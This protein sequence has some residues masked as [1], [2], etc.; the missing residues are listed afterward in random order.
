MFPVMLDVKRLKVL[1]VARGEHLHKRRVQLQQAGA[2]NVQEF[3]ETLPTP[4]EIEAAHLVLVAGLPEEESANI[5]ALARANNILVNVEDVIEQCDFFYPSIVRRG[6]LLLAISTCG[7]S[8]TLAQEVRKK[9]EHDFPAQWAQHTQT[10]K[11]LRQQW[12]KE[13]KTM[14]EVGELTR[15]FIRQQGWLPEYPASEAA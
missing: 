1:L 6:D 3:S 9:L 14:R 13:G 2:A 12:R 4:S 10:L 8:P 5:A 11:E 15:H 7:A